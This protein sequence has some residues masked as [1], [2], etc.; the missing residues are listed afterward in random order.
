MARATFNSNTVDWSGENP[1]MYLKETAD[2]PF[3]TLISFFRV[4]TSPHRKG[5]AAFMLLDPHGDGGS[6]QKP[7]VC[8]TDNEP[9]AE[10]L[11]KGFLSCFSAFKGVTGLSNLQ[12]KPGWDFMSGGDGRHFAYRTVQ[13]RHRPGKFDLGATL[14]AVHGGTDERAVRHRSPRDVLAVPRIHHGQS[15]NQWQER[16]RQTVPSRL[17]RTQEHDGVSGVFGNLDQSL[18]TAAGCRDFPRLKSDPK[19]LKMAGSGAK[20]IRSSELPW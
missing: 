13:Q 2:G 11:K 17:G 20:Q 15:L 19:R 10:Y 14:R 1:G 4:I 6:P 9:L 3:V 5:H 7:N 16:C 8:L 12:M 18:K